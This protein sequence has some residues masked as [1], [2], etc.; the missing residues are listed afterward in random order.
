MAESEDPAVCSWCQDR[1]SRGTL[2][3]LQEED[4]PVPAQ[5]MAA[6]S[7]MARLCSK[8]GKHFHGG[9]GASGRYSFLSD[10]DMDSDAE[11][12]KWKKGR[13]RRG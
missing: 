6:V 11:Q 1:A 10:A 4:D 5:G 13:R 9:S 2:I 7:E 3:A 12:K 8:C